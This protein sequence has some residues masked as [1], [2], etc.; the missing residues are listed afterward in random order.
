M[1]ALRSGWAGPSHAAGPTVKP[2]FP[3]SPLSEPCRQGKALP[4]TWLLLCGRDLDACVCFLS[5]DRVV[6]NDVWLGA[7]G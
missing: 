7:V 1:P 4:G 3:L 2:C 6:G 5:H